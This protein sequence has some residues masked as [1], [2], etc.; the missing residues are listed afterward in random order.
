MANRFADAV[1]GAFDVLEFLSRDSIDAPAREPARFDRASVA[2]DAPHPDRV[3]VV[4]VVL[5]RREQHPGFVC[6]RDDGHEPPC[7]L[8]PL[9]EVELE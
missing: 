1:R 3:R 8:E 2:P 4:A 9:D 7:Q 5:C 6:T